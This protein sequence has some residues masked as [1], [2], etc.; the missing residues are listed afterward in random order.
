MHAP[1]RARTTSIIRWCE[2]LWHQ[3]R[4]SARTTTLPLNPHPRF[5]ERYL[6]CP[7][8]ACDADLQPDAVRVCLYLRPSREHASH[9]VRYMRIHVHCMFHDVPLKACTTTPASQVRMAHSQQLCS[10]TLDVSRVGLTPHASERA[11]ES[12]VNRPRSLSAWA[13][14]WCVTFRTAFIQ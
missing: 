7:H 5:R 8:P 4:A 11:R 1:M 2:V 6:R 3:H 9:N 14:A 13:L 12:I 10:V